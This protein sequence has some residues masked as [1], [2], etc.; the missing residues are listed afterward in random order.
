M[1]VPRAKQEREISA[2]LYGFLEE[3]LAGREDI[4]ANGAERYVMRQFH[5]IMRD[6]FYK[7]RRAYMMYSLLWFIITG[8]FTFGYVMALGLGA[9]LFVS[10]AITLGV[11]YLFYQYT[12]M[13]RT[14]L[15]QMTRQLQDLQKA[16]AGILRVQELLDIK[17]E[18]K[19]EGKTPLPQGPLAVEFKDLTFSYNGEET[20]LEGVNMRL[21]PG[22]V[23]GLLGRTGS[24]KTTTTRLLFRLYEATGGSVKIGNV[25]VKDIPLAELRRRVG[26]VTQEVQLFHASVRDNLTFFNPEIPDEAILKVIREVGLWNWYSTLPDGLD[27]QLKAGGSGISAGEAQLLAFTR[28]FLQNPGLVVLDE[29]SSRLD[30]ATER[31]IEKAVD[32]LLENRTGFIIAHRLETVKRADTIIILE[33]GRVV[34][35]GPREELAV[36][37]DSRFYHLLQVGLEET[38]V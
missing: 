17:P 33:N 26:M 18:I 4:R 21:E 15:E 13:L 20:I 5:R 22:Q 10:G 19:D 6:F 14:P 23:L 32:K 9:Y 37:P 24:G 35:Y 2:T 12:E 34:E 29:A 7:T 3:R 36:D 8:L 30:P 16:T 31:L 28:L 27:S 11:V 38:L 1:A 25:D